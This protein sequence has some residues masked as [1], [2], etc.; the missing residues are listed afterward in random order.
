MTKKR[1]GILRGGSGQNYETSLRK[2]GDIF[3]YIYE[4]LG[5]YD[6]VDILVDRDGV[7]HL[8]GL[9]IE[10]RGL[11]HKVDVVWNVIGPELSQ[12]LETF[13]IP[14]VS[15]SSFASALEA[16][17][18]VLGDYIKNINLK[19]PRRLESPQ[20]A[21]AVHE[22][23]GGPWVVKNSVGMG[24]VTTFPELAY[25][26]ENSPETVV[27]E[28]IP[29]SAGSAHSLGGFRG[30]DVYV[31]SGGNFSQAEKE[32]IIALA[33]D[34]HRHL[35]AKYY[36]KSDFVVHP[37]RGVFLT[38]I[39][40]FPDLRKGSHLDTSLLSLGAKMHQLVDHILENAV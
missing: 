24:V 20:N 28:F 32:K 33:R 8:S 2:G 38:N 23:F 12:T 26:L 19:M 30:R 40:Y 14:H 11:I 35:G 17:R 1:I 31:F 39:E 18:E 5:R 6:P 4:N 13:S 25:A 37:K 22:K 21:R 15:I 34:L 10:P 7:W 36:L 29:G 9:P 3:A 27:E 16:N